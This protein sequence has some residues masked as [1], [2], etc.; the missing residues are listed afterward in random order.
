MPA[1]RRR[2]APP[3]CGCDAMPVLWLA[4]PGSLLVIARAAV[5]GGGGGRLEGAGLTCSLLRPL[6]RTPRTPP[7]SFHPPTHPPA[8]VPGAG[9]SPE[10]DQHP[11][12]EEQRDAAGGAGQLWGGGCWCRGGG[13]GWGGRGGGQADG[14]AQARPA[15][16]RWVL[17]WLPASTCEHQPI[18]GGG[19]CPPHCRPPPLPT[20]PLAGGCPCRRSCC[21]PSPPPAGVHL[22]QRRTHAGPGAG[23]RLAQGSGGGDLWWVGWGGVGWGGVGWRGGRGICVIHAQ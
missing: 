21:P 3:T 17:G 4:Q 22:S 6:P 19:P 13:L 2:T 9:G 8:A 16:G 7:A 12:R 11:V 5:S 15:S 23:W 1:Q 18:S 14:G 10:G 20:H